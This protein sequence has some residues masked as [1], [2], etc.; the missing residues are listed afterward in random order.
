MSAPTRAVNLAGGWLP[1]CLTMRRTLV[2]RSACRD[3]A[4]IFLAFQP[5]HSRQSL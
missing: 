4:T 2:R 1:D 3:P 5:H